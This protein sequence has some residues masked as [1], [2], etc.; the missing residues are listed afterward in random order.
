MG[1]YDRGLRRQ[2]HF[3]FCCFVEFREAKS[4]RSRCK[5]INILDHIN[6]IFH[7]CST[8][9]V[10]AAAS[11][12]LG[13]CFYATVF[14]STAKLKHFLFLFVELE[15]CP[16]VN[17][18]L[19]KTA[20]LVSSWLY[21]ANVDQGETAHIQFIVSNNMQVL[22]VAFLFLLLNMNSSTLLSQL[23]WK[24]TPGS[25]FHKSQ[26]AF[27]IIKN[28]PYYPLLFIPYYL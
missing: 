13:R 17:K 11:S 20:S 9:C 25:A 15:C 19:N 5:Q 23:H 2:S 6:T 14:T 1:Q 27:W 21:V 8:C 24:K 3:L 22:S 4:L 10:Y 12:C 7:C 18:W 28:I 26:Y 16:C